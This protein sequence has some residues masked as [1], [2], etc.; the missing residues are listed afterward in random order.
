M[1]RHTFKNNRGGKMES[2]KTRGRLRQ[3]ATRLDDEGRLKR[4]EWRDRETTKNKERW[5]NIL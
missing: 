1:R 5:S 3:I 2:R 4:T